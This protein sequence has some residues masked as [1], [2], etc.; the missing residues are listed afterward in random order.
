MFASAVFLLFMMQYSFS[1]DKKKVI[2]ALRLHFISKTEIKWMMILVNVFAIT[3]AILF[4]TKKIRPEPFFMGSFV[5]IV[6]MVSV[7]YIL[8]QTVYKKSATF[9]DRFIIFFNEDDVKLDNGIGY[10]F[11]KWKKF[12]KYFESENFFH[13]YFNDKT[14]FLLPKDGMD[15]A[16]QLD[17]RNCLKNKI[18][19]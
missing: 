14:F 3:S 1:Y 8:P 4:Y 19:R 18:P 5:W 13:L 10:V 9:K 17:V 15:D 6:M 7:W 2:H 16:L 11:W 12:R